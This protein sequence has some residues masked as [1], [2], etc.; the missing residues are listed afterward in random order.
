MSPI[1]ILP[2]PTIPPPTTL[3]QPTMQPQIIPTKK[4]Q[5]VAVIGAGAAGLVA[6]RELRREGHQ[7]VVFERNNRIGGTWVYDPNT[8]SDPLGLYPSR[9][10]V[11]A[12]LYESLRTNLPR[13]VMGFRDYPFVAKKD[14]KRRDSRR[15]PDHEEV[16]LYLEDF[17]SE[18]GIS[19]LI[20]LETEVVHVGLMG[21]GK[22]VVRSRKKD[23][24]V[25]GDDVFNA[26][27]VCNG[28]YTKPRVAEIP[29]EDD[30]FVD[31]NS[32]P[33]FYEYLVDDTMVASLASPIYDEYLEKDNVFV[34]LDSP[35]SVDTCVVDQTKAIDLSNPS[36]FFELSI[37]VWPGR[38]IHSHNYRVPDPFC[39][40]VVVLIG[41]SASAYDISR[42]IATVAKEVHVAARS[43]T[44]GTPT[45][46]VGYNNLWTHSMI[47]SAHKDG[48]AAVQDG[49]LL[50]VDVILHCTGGWS[51]FY[52]GRI[53]LPSQEEMMS[54]VEAFYLTLEAAGVPKRYT[55]NLGNCQFEY[56]DW[57]AAECRSSPSQEWRKQMYAANRM[58][59]AIRPETYP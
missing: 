48:T 33:I 10:I 25:A 43:T 51:V 22:W 49:S 16:L 23:R 15:F 26:V 44:N 30:F 31:F 36:N 57:L 52:H 42:E 21:E 20:R 59:R 47:K 39:K 19:E 2:S 35:P 5:K 27:V 45:K 1:I 28:H 6:T 9:T 18:F 55:H 7:V 41:S 46:L 4:S 40:K 50:L 37:G 17:M 34:P 29:E 56:N 58:N 32:S 8:E 12:S 24:N 13:E 38:Q 53:S 11:H 54:D 14:D 3:S